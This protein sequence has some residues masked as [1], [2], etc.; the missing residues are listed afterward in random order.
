VGRDG[1]VVS[2]NARGSA[3]APLVE[4]ALA[5]SP[6]ASED[7]KTPKK[8][9]GNE[10]ADLAKEKSK[11]KP[12][13]EEEAKKKAD[14]I[15]KVASAL[16]TWTDSSGKFK[17]QAKFRGVINQKVK[18]ERE[19]GSILNLPLEKLSD[20]DQDFVKKRKSDPT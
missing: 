13:A 19:D 5:E 4:K 16:R 2:L 1:K 6:A 7:K 17:I 3:L 15:P 12:K 20:E 18:L 14:E 11:G 10:E 8:S 9:S